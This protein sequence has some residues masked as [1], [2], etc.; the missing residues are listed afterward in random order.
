MINK[1][2]PKSEFGRNV[3]TLMT[4]TAVAQ[5][6]PIAISPI[7]TRLYTPEDFG[8]FALYIAIVSLL[9]IFVTGRYELAIMLP[10]SDTEAFYILVATLSISLLLSALIFI[11]IVL[12][13]PWIS[14]ITHNTDL[15]GWLYLIPVS[16]L[17]SGWYQ[18]LNFWT[19]R[20]K[21]YRSLS[22]GIIL[23]SSSNAL[24]NT[25]FGYLKLGFSGLITTNIISGFL[26]LFFLI[27][28]NKKH[29]K[30]SRS[31]PEPKK[32]YDQ[33]K[34]YKRFPLHT[35]PQNFVYQ[36]F[37][38]LPIFFI[39]SYF[40]TLIL[41]AYSLS[42]RTLSTPLSILSNSF[43]QVFY[44][45]ASELYRQDKQ[46]LYDYTK[47]TFLKLFVLSST[48]AIIGVWFLPD[49]FAFIFGTPWKIAGTIAQYLTIFLV[50][51]FAVEP[52]TKLYLIA[53]EN[54]FYL[55]W[56]IVRFVL[57]SLY[58]L[59]ISMFFSKLSIETFFLI[60]A[61]L[62]FFMYSF[63]AIP[64]LHKQSFLWKNK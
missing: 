49:I 7:L 9:S 1:L 18:S 14:Q 36:G 58:L 55:K 39:Q 44:Q 22:Q 28:R 20:K 15:G 56:E 59:F 64:I 2:K 3:V 24:F 63:I 21:D 52:L 61:L 26:S 17:I 51:K 54:L 62:Q 23:Q 34:R 29:L 5:A 37:Q 31:H 47:Q 40:S 27:Y 48:V 10:T 11:F 32:I 30:K 38:Q 43:G 42:L 50:L 45:K 8:I 19:N 6:I 13:A 4:G 33:L 35:L 41:G 25:S 57:I 60:F 53:E 12:C 16:I 46:T